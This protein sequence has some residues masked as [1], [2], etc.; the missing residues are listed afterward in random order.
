ML[1]N[2]A[3]LSKYAKFETKPKHS[4][5]F[6]TVEIR[7]LKVK[8]ELFI[9]IIASVLPAARAGLL[10]CTYTGRVTLVFSSA[11]VPTEV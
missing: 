7:L 10:I 11:H 6:P 1:Y 5:M 4:S 9:I 3:K 8:R 2:Y